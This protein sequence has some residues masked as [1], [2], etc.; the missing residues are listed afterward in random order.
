MPLSAKFHFGG[1]KHSFGEKRAPKC[2]LG[3]RV[4]RWC[5][6][7]I[8]GDAKADGGYA[9]SIRGRAMGGGGRAIEK[10]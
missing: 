9:W 6:L 4:P 7:R 10:F 5:A 8:D 1:A 2:N 3:A